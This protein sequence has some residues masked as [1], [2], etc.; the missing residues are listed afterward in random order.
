MH[1][2]E[3]VLDN[4]M[5]RLYDLLLIYLILSWNKKDS[6]VIFLV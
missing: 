3:T 2:L 4:K 6:G 5:Q 1:I